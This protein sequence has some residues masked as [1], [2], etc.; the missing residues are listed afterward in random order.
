MNPHTIDTLLRSFFLAGFECSSHL[1]RDGRRLDLLNSTGHDRLSSQDYGAIAEHGILTA[2]DGLR[3]H[4]IETAPGRYDWSSFLPMLRASRERGIQVIWDLCHY[5]WPEDIDIW[6]G[7][8]PERFAAFAGAAARIIRD[9]TGEP[10]LVCPLNEMSFWAWAG[11][12]VGQFAPGAQG[13]GLELKRQLVRAAIAGTAAI[14]EVDPDARFICAEPLI[15]VDP[16]ANTDPDHVRAAEHYRLSQYEAT[17]LLTGRLEPELGGRPDYLDI[18]G[19][20]FYSDNQWYYGGPTIPL[21]HHAYR[22]LQAMLA[23]WFERYRRPLLIAETGAEGSARPSWLHYVCAEVQAARAEGVHIEGACIYP[24]L[25]YSGWENERHCATGLLSAPDAS[26]RRRVFAP[27]AAEL[28][29][30]QA[31]FAT[32]TNPLL[33]AAE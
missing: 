33:I 15:H 17:D 23:E 26:G 29:R 31:V 22:P 13:R 19:V 14:R 16:G 8:F 24:I 28:R 20:N 32:D 2:R 9:Q 12:D 11:A 3:W 30:Q 1:R 4:L 5:G 6:S 25:E 27:L 10:P 18:V 21:G 7:A